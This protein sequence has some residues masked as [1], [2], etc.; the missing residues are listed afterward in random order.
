MKNPYDVIKRQIITEKTTKLA[1]YGAVIGTDSDKNYKEEVIRKYTFE[2]SKDAN[3]IE[4]KNAIEEIF[5][6]KN[7][8]VRSVNIVNVRKKPHKMGRYEG[9]LPAVR[10]AIVTLEKGSTIDVFEI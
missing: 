4:V 8:K 3:K 9:F 7:V 1:E 5:K 2:V 6:S 10:K